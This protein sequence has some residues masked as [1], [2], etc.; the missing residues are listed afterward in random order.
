MLV[1]SAEFVEGE[2]NLFAFKKIRFQ[3]IF[4]VGLLNI[5]TYYLF[6]RK[7][8]LIVLFDNRRV[9]NIAGKLYC[10]KNHPFRDSNNNE[11]VVKV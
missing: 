9:T 10:R 8:D 4:E 3:N 2:A 5:Y 6:D 7:L 11:S 1:F